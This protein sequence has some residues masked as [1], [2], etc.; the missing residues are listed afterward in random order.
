MFTKLFLK[1]QNET[2]KAL[3]IIFLISFIFLF[4]AFLGKVDTPID[5]RN[6]QMYP[7]RHYSVD[8]HINKTILWQANFSD[9]KAD[10]NDNSSANYF[11]LKVSPKEKESIV[12]PITINKLFLEKLNKIKEASYYVS[13]DFKTNSDISISYSGFNF[14]VFFVNKL[15]DHY[16]FPKIRIFR[17]EAD[18]PWYKVYLPLDKI[19]YEQGSIENLSSYNLVISGNNRSDSHAATLT[20][21]DLKIICDDFSNTPEVHNPYNNDLIQGFTPNREFF[22]NSLKKFKIPFWYNCLLTGLENVADPQVGYFHPLYFMIYFLFDHFTAH[23]IVTFFCFILCGI[24][25]F[26]LCRYWGLD[27]YPSLFACIVYM[28]HPFNVVWFSFEHSLMNSATLPFLLLMYEKNLASKKLLNKH[29][30]ISALL[31]GL[32]FLSG[33][34]QVSYYTAIFFILFASFR[35]LQSIFVHKINFFPYI[36][37]IIGLVFI[38]S[39]ALMMSAVV[40][41]PLIP[42][43]QNSYRVSW[44]TETIKSSSVPLKAF[45]GLLY[46]Y[47]MGK[48]NGSFGEPI[49][50]WGFPRNY[51]YFGLLPFLLSLFCLRSCFKNKL[52]F[53]FSLSII[54]SLL[55]CTGS[56]FFF[57]IKDFIPGFKQLQHQRFIEVYSYSV[58]FLAGIGLQTF[59]KTIPGKEQFKSILFLLII[60]ISLSDLIFYSSYFIT[61][62]DRKSYKPLHKG[63]SLEFIINKAK[64]SKEPF[65][66]LSFTVHKMGN[67]QFKQDTS[68]A[69]PNTLLPYGIEDASGYS[70][71]VPEDIYSLFV[72]I[73]TKDPNKLYPKEVLNIFSNTNIPYPIYNF[74]SKIL[75]LLN[76]RYFL[77]PNFL[78][79]DSE[80]TKKVYLGDCAIYENKDYLPRAFVVSKY[81]LIKSKKETIMKLDSDDFN[82]R[83]EVILMSFPSQSG[84]NIRDSQSLGLESKVEFKEYQNEKINL[85]VQVNR[86]S[87]LVFGSNLNYNW[88]VKVNGKKSLLYQANLVQ[89]AV[90][91][92]KAGNHLVE[93]YYYPKLFLIGALISTL[94]VLVLFFLAFWLRFNKKNYR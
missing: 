88:R 32:I 60:L 22:S 73:Q 66:I 54:I 6:V 47:Y 16:F 86:P 43:V 78:T 37:Q 31:L 53:F 62:S 21:K 76:V 18:K 55:I 24:G 52:V 7:W 74:K 69:L 45:L 71:F 36:K 77:V 23:L 81:R 35:F 10:I 79:L 41:I 33:H 56:S 64:L 85:S 8:S 91:L 75:D 82:L 13:F 49:Y 28:F 27:F 26:S 15:T 9:R 4:P 68:V 61:W 48:N 87:I 34:L 83:D 19:L 2:I 92:P 89:K 42:F 90:Y 72:Y 57:L 3:L 84:D 5:I 67:L 80:N 59:M 94:A 44:S 63:G 46:P 30:L 65:R 39:I 12:F 14:G 93:F 50:G 29:L 70:S 38:C 40:L 20:V 17:D 1:P 58:P 51:M 11:E 25:T